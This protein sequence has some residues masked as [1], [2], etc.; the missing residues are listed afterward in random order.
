MRFQCLWLYL[1]QA[2]SISVLQVY[3]VLKGLQ[4]M[5]EQKEIKENKE[6]RAEEGH[7]GQWVS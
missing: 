2:D 1:G 5:L 6:T 4:D 3:L 7:L